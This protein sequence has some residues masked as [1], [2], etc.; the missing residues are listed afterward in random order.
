MPN[1]ALH[2]RHVLKSVWV[3]DGNIS[4]ELMKQR[5]LRPPLMLDGDG[6]YI[7]TISGPIATNK[8]L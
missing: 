3:Y 8:L 2:A 5:L 4:P 6:L 7:A 1:L